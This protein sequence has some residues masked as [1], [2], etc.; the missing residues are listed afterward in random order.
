[1]ADTIYKFL[2]EQGYLYEPDMREENRIKSVL[3][4]V[5]SLVQ[6]YAQA[7]C[8]DIPV[9]CV[10]LPYGSY[11][12]GLRTKGGDI[13]CCIIACHHHHTNQEEIFSLVKLGTFIKVKKYRNFMTLI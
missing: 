2:T 7:V 6:K 4:L 5:Q 9:Q 13:D 1:M 10:I 8:G 12:M 11:R 3:N